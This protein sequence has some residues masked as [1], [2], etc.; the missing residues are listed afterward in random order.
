[1]K[2]R[3]DTQ[4]AFFYLRA[5]LGLLLAVAGVF[6][7]LLGVGQFTVQA[8]QGHKE[9]GSAVDQLVPAGFDCGQTQAL[10]INK[11]ENFRA[12]AIAIFCGDS[13]GGSPSP[14]EQTSAIVQEILDPLLGTTDVDLVTGTETTPHVIQSETFSTSN[15]DNPNEIVVAYNDSRSAALSNFSG[16][17]VSSDGGITFTRVTNSSGRSPFTNTFG[18]PVILYN[19][20]SATWF[21][22]WL[23]GGAGG[24]GIGGYKS[25]TPAD[26]NSWTHFVIHT[27]S[28]DDRESGWA[29]NNP[30][31][32]FYGRMYVSFN[33]FNRGGGALFVRYTTDN[34]LTWNNERQLSTGFFRDVQITGDPATGAVYV[35]SMNEEGGGLTNRSN[36]LY[37]SSDGGATFTQVYAGP[38][39]AAPGRTTCPNSY[40]A[41]MYNISGTGYWRHMGWG[42]PAVANSVV[43]YVYD[44]RNTSNGDPGNV[45]YIRSTDGGAT[46]SAP[47]QLNTDTGTRAQ[48]QPNISAA[49]DGSLVAVWYDERETSVCTKGSPTV[50]CYRMWARKSLDNGLTWMPDA[51]FSDTIS[52]LP[53]QSDPNIVAEYVGD[54]DYSSSSPTDH[55]HTWTDGRVA[56]SG[57]SQQD[58]FVDREPT[59]GGGGGAN[60]VSA[61]SR[62]T[63]GS[64]GTFDI[65]MPLTG[66][67]GVEDRVAGSYLAVFTFDTAVTSGSA[68][69]VSGVGTAGTPTFSGN[70]MLVPLNGVAN[71]QILTIRISGVNGGS[72][73]AD[74]PFGFLTADA[75][76][77][78]VVDRPDK[79]LIQGQVKMPV[80]SANFREDVDAD[81]RIG[82]RDVKQVQTHRGESLP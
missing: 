23:D 60:L 47:F 3:S 10:G 17:S 9:T 48:W 61:A 20:P 74:V 31:S 79:T 72:G 11:Q 16:A 67:S 71:E 78:R 40:F 21:T 37:K 43:H 13:V 12:G 49:A 1:M 27:N 69:I 7:A 42:Q 59:T 70:N 64:A 68:S 22:V 56:I 55:I 5:S 77:S 38:T 58:A 39:F 81:G 32:P 50:P 53:G 35:A 52:P 44:S 19:R 6:L 82:N 29:D 66:T 36:L 45:F 30:S 76:A 46:F 54:Y 8:Q 15:P 25:T 62:L 24:Q 4:S 41:C 2:K 33:D 28:S 63:H 73:T 26:P 57:A 80:T 75:D 14:A 34:G 65:A 51:P 18:D